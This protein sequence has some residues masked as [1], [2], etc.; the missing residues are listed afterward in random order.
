MILGLIGVFIHY[1]KGWVEA[2]NADQKYHLR[3]ALPMAALSSLTTLVAIYM[4]DDI[5]TLYPITKFS[6]VALGYMGNS[7]FFSFLDTKK[8]KQ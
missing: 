4:K 6:A 3:K 2:N 1:F 8:P 7:I 5:A